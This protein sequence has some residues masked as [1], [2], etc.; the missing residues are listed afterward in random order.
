MGAPLEAGEPDQ[1][2]HGIDYQG[3]TLYEQEDGTL[4]G[5]VSD[6][7]RVA[8]GILEKKNVRKDVNKEAQLDEK[9]YDFLSRYTR[10]GGNVGGNTVGS[11]PDYDKLGVTYQT[12]VVNDRLREYLVYVPP[13]AKVAA[14]AR[15][16]CAPGVHD[17]R[18]RDD[19]VHDV[20]LLAMVGGGQQGG[21]H[22]GRAHVNEQRTRHVVVHR[23]RRAMTSPSS[24]RCSP[25]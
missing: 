24:T 17:A 18:V 12:L 7:S 2:S 13:K 8:V 23:A 14:G 11:R 19:D 9:I 10:Y 3:G 22:P 5:Y 15:Q 1:L 21:V 16:G 4:Y 20:R 6:S 25:T